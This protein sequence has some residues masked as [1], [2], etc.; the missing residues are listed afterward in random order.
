MTPTKTI[1]L[2]ADIHPR[3]YA[4]P[5]VVRF[6]TPTSQFSWAPAP[7][8]RYA[9]CGTEYGYLHTTAGGVR[10]WGSYSGA[11]KAAKAYQPL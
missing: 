1:P 4:K 2:W 8:V 3:S 10:T 5:T 6:R 11:H 9:V 7:E